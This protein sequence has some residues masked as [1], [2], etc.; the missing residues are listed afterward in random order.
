MSV[1][2]FTIFNLYNN[3]RSNVD[4][5]KSRYE[6]RNENGNIKVLIATSTKKWEVVSNTVSLTVESFRKGF[7]S[8][9]CVAIKRYHSRL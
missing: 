1:Q 8:L 7:I 5:A 2:I 9:V 3:L 6:M 4:D